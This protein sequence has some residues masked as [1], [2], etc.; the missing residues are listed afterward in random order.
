MAGSVCD[1]GR[2]RLDFAVNRHPCR[3][4]P[5]KLGPG[6]VESTGIGFVQDG[7]SVDGFLPSPPSRDKCAN[8]HLKQNCDQPC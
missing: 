4:S 2:T 3:L 8:V 6:V 5:S 7:Q 1:T